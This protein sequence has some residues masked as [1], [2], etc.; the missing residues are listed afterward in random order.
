MTEGNLV[1][2]LKKEGDAV[3]A[4]QIIAELK[5]TRRRWKSRPLMKARLQN[6]DP[7]RYARRQVNAPIAI[8]AEEDESIEEALV[9][10]EN[11]PEPQTRHS[12]ESR[13]PVPARLRR[14]SLWH[15]DPRR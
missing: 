4:G 12:G 2:W 5:P 7:R 6:P 13:N 3:K 11:K 1:K 14:K 9:K 15:V 10:I 8:L